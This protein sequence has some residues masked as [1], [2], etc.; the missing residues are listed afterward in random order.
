MK[1]GRIVLQAAARGGVRITTD[2]SGTGGADESSPSFTK[3]CQ[4]YFTVRLVLV[5]LLTAQRFPQVTAT[6]L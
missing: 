1:G 3:S 5:A 4:K 6:R 2:S